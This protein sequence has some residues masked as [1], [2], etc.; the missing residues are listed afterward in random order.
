MDFCK[1]TLKALC[2]R[3]DP[4]STLSSE[5]VHIR[6][7]SPDPGLGFRVTQ[8]KNIRSWLFA[9]QRNP[10][11]QTMI[12]QVGV[13]EADGKHA[14]SIEKMGRTVGFTPGLGC[15]LCAFLQVWSVDF[16]LLCRF[17]V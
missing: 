10:Q 4:G 11:F 16:G 7:S 1:T 15:R 9:R 5:L 6:Q 14:G 2:V 13:I 3:K 8:F 12:L 17:G